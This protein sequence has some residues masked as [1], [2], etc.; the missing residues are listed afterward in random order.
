MKLKLKV[1][2][3]LKRNLKKIAENHSVERKEYLLNAFKA[4]LEANKEIWT[5][6]IETYIETLKER[7]NA[8]ESLKTSLLESDIS[9]DEK[10]DIMLK[11]YTDNKMYKTF[12]NKNKKLENIIIDFQDE[13][14]YALK[15]IAENHSKTVEDY[16][17]EFLHHCK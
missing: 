10:R 9:Q 7:E 3:S 12:N 17:V 5:G 14:F 2:K 15:L 4:L 13:D 11:F 16:S 8:L 6:N 1:S